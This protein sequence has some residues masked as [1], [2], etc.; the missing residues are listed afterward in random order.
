MIDSKIKNI[1][2]NNSQINPYKD[3]NFKHFFTN[4]IDI[5]M[6][7]ILPIDY[8]F[9]LESYDIQQS[10]MKN[11]IFPSKI[12]FPFISRVIKD[13]KSYLEIESIELKNSNVFNFT[14]N[15]YNEKG[16]ITL[17]EKSF[18]ELR[19]QILFMLLIEFIDNS[20]KK[21]S[22]QENDKMLDLSKYIDY[23][24]IGE[25]SYLFDVNFSF[26]NFLSIITDSYLVEQFYFWFSFFMPYLNCKIRNFEY[27]YFMYDLNETNSSDS[28]YNK[29]MYFF[30]EYI[31]F[32]Q[33]LINKVKM[34]NNILT[35]YNNYLWAEHIL[36][37]LKNKIGE[38][39]FKD[40]LQQLVNYNLNQINILNTLLL[41]QKLR[42]TENIIFNH[43]KLNFYGKNSS[44]K[45]D[46][47]I[48]G[49]LKENKVKSIIVNFLN[50]ENFEYL[51]LM[52]EKE[53]IFENIVNNAVDILSNLKK[54]IM[55]A[56]RKYL[57][58]IHFSLKEFT[59]YKSYVNN[60]MFIFKELIKEII[61]KNSILHIQISFN[62]YSNGVDID[63]MFYNYTFHPDEII[64]NGFDDITFSCPELNINEEKIIKKSL[65]SKNNLFPEF[66]LIL[67]EKNIKVQINKSIDFNFLCVYNCERVTNLKLGYF[68]N[69]SQLEICLS[70]LKLYKMYRL[71]KV[72]FFIKTNKGINQINLKKFFELQF[73]KQILTSIKIIYDKHIPYDN[74]DVFSLYEEIIVKNYFAKNSMDEIQLN[75]LPK[76][77]SDLTTKKQEGIY[78]LR[79]F[80]VSMLN[81]TSMISNNLIQGGHSL[82]LD[83]TINNRKNELKNNF[84][85][86][87]LELV[88]I[89]CVEVYVQFK[90]NKNT[91]SKIFLD[92]PFN[93][94]FDKD[95]QKK[96]LR[97]KFKNSIIVSEYSSKINEMLVWIIKKLDE[98]NGTKNYW[99]LLQTI[100]NKG[101]NTNV[102]LFQRIFMFLKGRR[103]IYNDFPNSYKVF[104]KYKNIIQNDMI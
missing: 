29:I 84:S 33:N 101:I 103:V 42:R 4:R 32:C 102:N 71:K 36:G 94:K 43:L 1:K 7:S 100:K 14:A 91:L 69:L 5:I 79:K 41:Q 87:P 81:D 6:K 98:K 67:F 11:S 37:D 64:S 88:L 58:I 16:I 48:T 55:I 2:T 22:T 18:D 9:H 45:F 24:K 26:Q 23:Y 75:K 70:K 25:K 21:Y 82:L 68:I 89:C 54:A 46:K 51:L 80:N 57:K 63:D 20:K 17:S 76:Y 13:H 10:T 104:K 59:S 97:D 50:F 28:L 35:L 86:Y 8:E 62:N 27:E 30:T 77:Q 49:N 12:L 44:I 31:S 34:E 40:Y 19:D 99:K 83:S 74:I 60:I 47:F 66:K 73:P 61:S 92:I 96:K 90:L 78:N 95:L 15:P 56:D 53:V 85:R 72:T 3:N 39:R 93:K 38:N 65:S 52:K